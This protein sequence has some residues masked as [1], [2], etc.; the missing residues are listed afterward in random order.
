MSYIKKIVRYLNFY[1]VFLPCIEHNILHFSSVKYLLKISQSLNCL[2]YCTFF[3]YS[4]KCKHWIRFL[5]PYFIVI[6][7]LKLLFGFRFGRSRFASEYSSELLVLS[8]RLRIKN[9]NIS[10]N[11][12]NYSCFRS[13]EVN[14]LLS[15]EINKIKL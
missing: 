5:R 4:R 2:F 8:R 7:I 15:T 11:T 14:S 9:K 10:K 13:F 12:I 3:S 1:I 6:I